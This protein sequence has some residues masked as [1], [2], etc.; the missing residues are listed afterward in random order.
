M[1]AGAGHDDR[2]QVR[3]GIVSQSRYGEDR[4]WPEMSGD[5]PG[6]GVGGPERASP[7]GCAAGARAGRQR[8]EVDDGERA[9]V[10][11]GTA[12]RASGR[13]VGGD[14]AARAGQ[15]EGGA[16]PDRGGAMPWAGGAGEQAPVRPVVEGLVQA[17]DPR[18]RRDPGRPA[19]AAAAGRTAG[20]T[21]GRTGHGPA[22]RC[23]QA[24]GAGAGV[25]GQPA[26][27]RAGLRPHGGG[28]QR[29]DRPAAGQPPEHGGAARSDVGPAQAGDA[30]QHQR[31]RYC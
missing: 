4:P 31:I 27:R 6:L 26:V 21:R 13:Q 12:G 20:M 24:G 11:L 2:V 15:G 1:V 5:P 30:D 14:A 28:D 29:P 7:G 3:S 16:G 17:D 8:A 19:A 25:Q 9:A 22:G 10:Q 23:G 18:H